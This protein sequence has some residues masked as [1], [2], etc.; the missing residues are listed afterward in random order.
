MLWAAAPPPPGLKRSLLA[1]AAAAAAADCSF[2]AD[3]RFVVSASAD[4]TCRLWSL[5]RGGEL[6]VFQGHDYP[7]RR[8]A[9]S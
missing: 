3:R 1:A 4:T 6:A 8:A 7:V 2:S 9:P 5:Q